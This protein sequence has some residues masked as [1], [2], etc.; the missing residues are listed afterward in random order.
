MSGTRARALAIGAA[1]STVVILI[2]FFQ[3]PPLPVLIGALVAVALLLL[4]GKSS[5]SR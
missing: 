1:A 2:G 5:P 4:R 3:A